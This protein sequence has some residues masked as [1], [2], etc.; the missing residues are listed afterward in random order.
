MFYW[1]KPDGGIGLMHRMENNATGGETEFRNQV[2]L[3]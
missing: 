2:T 3:V 1:Q